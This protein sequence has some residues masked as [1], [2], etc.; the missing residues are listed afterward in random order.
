MDSDDDGF[1]KQG[2]EPLELGDE[3]DSDDGDADADADDSKQDAM[4]QPLK[5]N[6]SGKGNDK[7]DGAKQVSEIKGTKVENQPFDLAV[8]V[9]DSEEI[10]SDEED[11]QV[12]VDVNVQS[13]K[14]QMAGQ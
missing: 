5:G 11:D 14:A 7:A 3:F 10:D 1:P 4:R 12:N 9:D 6:M 8:D 2:G 13:S